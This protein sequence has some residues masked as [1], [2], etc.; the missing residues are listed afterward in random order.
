MPFPLMAV[1][2]GISLANQIGKWFSG[3][4][5]TKEAKKINPVFNQYKTNP[6][7]KTQLGLAQQLFGGRMAGATEMEKNILSSQGSVLDGIDRTATDGAQALAAKIATQGQTDQ[8]FS[9]LQ[10]LEKQNKYDMLSNLNESYGQLINEGDKEYDS[11]LEKFRFDSG[12]KDALMS[13]GKMNKYGAVNDISSL[14]MQ[15]SQLMGK[16][17]KKSLAEFAQ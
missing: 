5:Q 8:S 14:A 13:A 3:N 15:Y 11:M 6:Y 10:T 16:N 1:G 2:A 12:R 7:A 4:K 9:N 17:K